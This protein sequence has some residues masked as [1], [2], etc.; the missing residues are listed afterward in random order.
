MNF[1]VPRIFA[2]RPRTAA[3]FSSTNTCGKST[4]VALQFSV[5]PPLFVI[6]MD[7]TAGIAPPA[8]YANCRLEGATAIEAAKA[9]MML[10]ESDTDD[11]NCTYIVAKPGMVKSGMFAGKKATEID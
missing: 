10:I 11:D 8:V 4:I 3:G 5:P 9:V 1:E 2:A 6:W 7:C